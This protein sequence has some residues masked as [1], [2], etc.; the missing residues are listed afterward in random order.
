[1]S[2]GGHSKNNIW[3]FNTQVDIST[4]VLWTISCVTLPS[5]SSPSGKYVVEMTRAELLFP[6]WTVGVTVLGQEEVLK[7]KLKRSVWFP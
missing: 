4:R 1:M 7:S 5:V 3:V 6:V 2:A